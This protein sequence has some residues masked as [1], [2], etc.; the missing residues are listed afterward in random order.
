MLG[1]LVGHSH[2]MVRSDR[3][4]LARV[5][6]GEGFDQFFVNNVDHIG[7]FVLASSNPDVVGTFGPFDLAASI[8]IIVWDILEHDIAYIFVGGVHVDN[9]HLVVRSG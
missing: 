3:K 5:D 9:G 1:V 7:F 4:E 6:P 8:A 2:E